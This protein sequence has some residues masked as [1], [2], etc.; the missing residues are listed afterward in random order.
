MGLCFVLSI[1]AAYKIKLTKRYFFI[2]GVNI[3][4]VL[5]IFF[6]YLLTIIYDKWPIGT[7]G[8][9]FG[10]APLL[11]LIIGAIIIT[12]IIYLINFIVMFSKRQVNKN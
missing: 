9:L 10:I 2:S 7:D 4:L 5:N 1:F 8:I 3:G 12:D 6:M 11:F